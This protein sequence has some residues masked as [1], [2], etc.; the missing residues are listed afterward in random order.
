[1]RRYTQLVLSTAALVM[2]A[3]AVRAQVVTSAGGEVSKMTQKQF[4]DRLIV[5]DSIEIAMAQLAVERTKNPAVKDFANTLVTDHRTPL[6]S[7][8]ALSAKP[9]VGREEVA[10]DLEGV[11][12]LGQLRTMPADSTFDRAFI[13]AQIASHE[14]TID[15]V[16]KLRPTVSSP[17]VQQLVDKTVPVL[18]QHLAAAKVISAQIPP[19]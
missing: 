9:D 12:V 8:R 18:E 5:G 15:M 17:E 6:D 3:S 13:N 1:M 7:L 14:R 10:G 16:K 2:T 11:R 19:K 4:V